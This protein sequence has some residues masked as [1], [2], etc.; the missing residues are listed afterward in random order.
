[1]RDLKVN[2]KVLSQEYKRKIYSS[3]FF[4]GILK[5]KWNNV[6]YVLLYFEHYSMSE[7]NIINRY[8]KIVKINM[9]ERYKSFLLE[10]LTTVKKFKNSKYY[11]LICSVYSKE[12]IKIFDA[13]LENV[14]K[15]P[16]QSRRGGIQIGLRSSNLNYYYP[17]IFSFAKDLVSIQYVLEQLEISY[18]D[19]FST[20]NIDKTV[21]TVL[22]NKRYLAAILDSDTN[23]EI[24]EVLKSMVYGNENLLSLNNEVIHGM[25]LSNNKEAQK[26][27]M[28]LLKSAKL[29]EGLRQSIVEW[30]DMSTVE[31]FETFMTYI[32]LENLVRFSSVKRAYLTYVGMDN[33][34]K[35]VDI[36]KFK[37]LEEAFVNISKKENIE[38]YLNS[39]N[40]LKFYLGLFSLGFHDT[41]DLKKYVIQTEHRKLVIMSF[42]MHLGIGFNNTLI[43]LLKDN[44]SPQ[45]FN[46]VT[47][48]M[49]KY[50]Y[51][52][53]YLHDKNSISEKEEFEILMD[54]YERFPKPCRVD[55]LILDGV[56]E[57]TAGDYDALISRLVMLSNKIND[58]KCYE[59]L[60]KHIEDLPTYTF[61]FWNNRALYLPNI[62]TPILRNS[63]ITCLASKRIDL[64]KF[65]QLKM[66]QFK[67]ELTIEET[68]KIAE[69]YKFREG[70][71]RSAITKTLCETS[72]DNQKYVIK[73]LLNQ[74]KENLK[75]GALDL[76]LNLKE[77]NIKKLELKTLIEIVNEEDF[78]KESQSLIAK[79]KGQEERT[80]IF[81]DQN[82][83]I[84]HKKN[85]YNQK[86]IDDFI[87]FNENKLVEFIYKSFEFVISL[88]GREYE[89]EN[90]LGETITKIYSI[91][92]S[93]YS[94]KKLRVEQY[95][96]GD[97]DSIKKYVFNEEWITFF[98]T[99]NLSENDFLNIHLLTR[100]YEK[101]ESTPRDDKPLNFNLESLVDFPLFPKQM[102]TAKIFLAHKDENLKDFV[103]EVSTFY[104]IYQK[105]VGNDLFFKF[106]E[107]LVNILD[108]I[109]DQLENNSNSLFNKNSELH[110]ALFS[111]NYYIV[112]GDIQF[113][114]SK[115]VSS[116]L[117]KYNDL[118]T[119]AVYRLP[120]RFLIKFVEQG[121]LKEDYIY[122][123]AFEGYNIQYRED[124]KKSERLPFEYEYKMC[125]KLFNQD[126]YVKKIYVVISNNILKKEWERTE[127]TT[128]YS[129]VV[130]NLPAYFGVYNFLTTIFKMGKQTFHRKH[131]WSISNKRETFSTII[132]RCE[133]LSEDTFELFNKLV[134][135]YEITETRL[136]EAT[137]YNPKFS[138]FTEQ[139]LNWPGLTETVYFFQAHVTGWTSEDRR[140][141][142]KR[143]TSIEL[144]K[145]NDGAIDIGWFNSSVEKLGEKRFMKLYDCAKYIIDGTNYKRI[146][147]FS[148]A[149]LGNLD[150][151]DLEKDIVDKRNKDK[152]LAY[153]LIP[154]KKDKMK[155]CISRYV[156]LQQFA[157][158]SKRFGSQRQATE[159]LKVSI[160]MENLALNAGYNDP[161][162][163]MWRMETEVLEEI[164][165][166]FN[167][168]KIEDIE[169]YLEL[170]NEVIP[171]VVVIKEGKRLKAVPVKYKKNE[172]IVKLNEAKKELKAMSI[173]ARKSLE[174]AMINESIFEIKELNI[175]FNNPIISKYLKNLVFKVNNKVGLIENSILKTLNEEIK[176]KDSDQAI[177]VHPIELIDDNTWTKWQSKILELN[178]K[179]PFKQIFR[180]CYT[181]TKEEIKNN[182]FTNRFAGYQ[183]EPKQAHA[184]LTKRDWLVNE[185]QGFEKIISNNN[186]RIDLYSYANWY[187]PAEIESPSLEK[188]MFMDNKT[189]KTIDMK[190]LSK[191]YYSEVLRDIDLVVSVAYVG[192][193]DP[194]MNHSTIE[195]RSSIIN[196]NLDL[197]KLDNVKL[198]DTFA[199]IKG[200]YGEYKIHLGSGTVHMIGKGMVP[201]IP[202]LSQYKNHIFLPFL[203]TDPKT[204]EIVSKILLFAEDNKIKDPSITQY[205]R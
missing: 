75:L 168:K 100:I 80:D 2:Y 112:S 129:N 130:A 99:I 84:V 45:I 58:V 188:V 178:I 17:I 139:Y 47:N 90:Y 199:N 96:Y 11:K 85:T 138:K 62:D 29:S 76:L 61:N 121:F 186:L 77:N 157:S 158:E 195:M 55:Y 15:T 155:D 87:N 66:E 79:L 170:D 106:Q 18:K 203:D 177:I 171:N 174:V 37:L 176:L 190:N 69:A 119:D 97:K 57:S 191:V 26:M 110:Y 38:K 196:Y 7:L 74:K 115:Y 14:Q 12:Q 149:L 135:E 150:L 16:Y 184:I 107:K 182:G 118:T 183:I 181:M 173:R 180:E 205:L 36:R 72:F 48:S 92:S 22:T 44:K 98:E 60:Y 197:F 32:S 117:L 141:F 67:I 102:K 109:T 63:L 156:F 35:V 160:A 111:R 43:G 146:Q 82:Y 5:K 204:A 103:S 123:I 28:D 165:G 189:G 179:Q 3:K 137:M 148:D 33:S 6:A 78:P 54:N 125:Y 41:E 152:L 70:A 154:L 42:F 91:N 201:V 30:I 116:V 51:D 145:L 198:N 169:V 143:Y 8:G 132:R 124:E 194:L 40:S 167:Q 140:L 65:G 64:Q 108:Y 95:R 202:V 185:Y 73:Y 122:K 93:I 114:N 127:A 24:I 88:K 136:L 101:L 71:V 187:S 52:L 126:E 81:Y 23:I 104:F 153:S 94:S 10:E 192:G 20:N 9:K 164:R 83:K 49:S 131:S 86:I 134:K 25:L 59:R 128:K 147:Y 163:F 39:E 142:Y 34:I 159:K 113:Y 68:I 175:L 4:S 13:F 172:Y 21:L 105:Y 144:K 133:P 56:L 193:V 89:D 120:L 161:V 50:S 1:M 31:T 200:A 46:I 53:S 19:Y 162:I 166:Y 27:V 151:K